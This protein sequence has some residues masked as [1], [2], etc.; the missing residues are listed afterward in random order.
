VDTRKSIQKRNRC[1]EDVVVKNRA[2]TPTGT[3]RHKKD[4]L[5]AGSG[6]KKDES[7]W[8]VWGEGDPKADEEEEGED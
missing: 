7:T 3:V 8:E 4:R 5:G 1:V 2:W 6:K